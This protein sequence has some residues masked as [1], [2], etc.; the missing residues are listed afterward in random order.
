MAREIVLHLVTKR[1][2]NDENCLI[3]HYFAFNDRRKA[4][5]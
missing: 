5:D 2:G 4:N 1:D 3:H